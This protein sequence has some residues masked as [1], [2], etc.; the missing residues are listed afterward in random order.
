M[1]AEIGLK[2]ET[3]FGL[4]WLRWRDELG[5]LLLT[6]DEIAAKAVAL[7]QKYRDRFGDISE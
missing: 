5:N 3:G 6:C 1:G 2:Q 7:L 4:C